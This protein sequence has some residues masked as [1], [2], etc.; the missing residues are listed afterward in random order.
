MQNTLE[1][2]KCFSK[3]GQAG[4]S[5]HDEGVHARPSME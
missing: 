2:A 5:C 3:L 4:S 1:L